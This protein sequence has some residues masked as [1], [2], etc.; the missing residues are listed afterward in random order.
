MSE[1]RPPFEP[2]DRVAVIG[3]GRSGEAASRLAR[4]RGA[5][6]YASDVAEGED[7]RRAAERLRQEDVDA[8]TGGHDI[9]RILESDLAVMSP[10]VPPA[11]EVRQA[12]R[13]GGVST[14][15]EIELAYR[16]LSSRIVAVSGTNG[17]TTTTAL[18]GHLLSQSGRTGETAGNIGRALS[19]VALQD[20]Q[21]EWAVVEVSSFQLADVRDFRPDVGVLLNLAPDHLDRYRDLERYYQDKRR[22]FMNATEESRWVLNLDDPEVL[23]LA[24]GAAGHHHHFSL[25][26]EPES[27][28]YM[29]GERNLRLVLPERSEA[30]VAVDDLT[31]VGRHNVANALAA[32]LAAALA[33]CTSDEISRGLTS[34]EPLPHRLEPV[35]SDDDGRLWVND[36]KA[37]N[38]S[39]TAVALEAFDR[40]LV[41]LMGGRGKGEPYISL[42]PL[43]EERVRGLVAFGESA[44]QIVSDLGDAAPEVRCVAAVDGAVRAARE[45]ARAGDVI[46]FSPACSSYDMFPHYRARG[47]AFAEAVRKRIGPGEEAS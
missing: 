30:W 7:Q 37:T 1:R 28:A 13:D 11:S 14:I 19:E 47:E 42:A 2:G 9:P 20:E 4:R 29:N 43:V 18:C 27:G 39:A 25:E 3:L 31:L 8:E 35:L 12:L 40:P 22:L 6:V 36:S 33:D 17:K 41:L 10:G 38:L 23:S 15:A 45:M 26:E 46:L 44:P 16:F 32:G 21:P 5:R 34:F 24:N